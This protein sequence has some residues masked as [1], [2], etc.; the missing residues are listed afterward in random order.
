MGHCP[1][2]GFKVMPH[3][4]ACSYCG[5][6]EFQMTVRVY[7]DNC[8]SCNPNSGLDAPEGRTFCPACSGEGFRKYRVTKDARSGILYYEGFDAVRQR[9]YG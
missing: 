1:E 4:T 6:R 8:D 3:E 5:N 9:Y 2:C 7:W